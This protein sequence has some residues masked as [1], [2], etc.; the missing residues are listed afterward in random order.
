[1]K[2][3]HADQFRGGAHTHAIARVVQDVLAAQP[4]CSQCQ[5]KAAVCVVNM[6]GPDDPAVLCR[7]CG[8]EYVMRQRIQ[9]Q[10]ET[11]ASMRGAR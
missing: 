8:D 1:M 5:R 10:R 3:E 6:V 4:P 7:V 11:R 2:L 9:R